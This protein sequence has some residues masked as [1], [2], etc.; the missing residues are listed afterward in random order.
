MF[1][2][3]FKAEWMKVRWSIILGIIWIAPALAIFAGLSGLDMFP[4]SSKWL[5]VYLMGVIQYTTLFLPI[6]VGIFAAFVCRYEHVGGGWKLT[7]AL[8]ASRTQVFLA[9]YLLVILLA[10]GVQLLLLLGIWLTG[11]L[12]DFG[13]SFPWK[14]IGAKIFFG[15]V[16]LLPLAAL[17]LWVSYL[18]KNFA[19]PLALN[20]IFTIPTILVAQSSLGSYYPWAQPFLA[21]IPSG[22]ELAQNV[23]DLM[24]SMI[25]GSWILFF[26][27]GLI[28]FNRR[29]WT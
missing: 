25:I 7:L 6:L 15:W 29:D 16:M 20:V 5:T 26:C 24:Y 27:G 19:A 4:G 2:R 22:Q 17:Q 3:V 23:P 18:W 21:M 28:M 14:E 11:T 13:G 12:L 8:P 1:L 9:K 10:A